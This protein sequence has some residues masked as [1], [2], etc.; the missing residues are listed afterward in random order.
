MAN[1]RSLVNFVKSVN[2]LPA[3][4]NGEQPSIPFALI[5][6]LQAMRHCWTI[7]R[8]Q[9]GLAIVHNKLTQDEL[10]Q[11]LECMEEVESIVEM[12]PIPPPLPKKFGSF[13]KNWHVFLEGFKGHC[14]V[15][16]GTLCIPL[17]FILREHTIISPEHR[18][19]NY[20]TANE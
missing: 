8:Q 14:S 13:G 6:L 12:K 1:D 10:K 18:G 5:R 9:C 3:D 20:I 7:E 2:K 15:V 17:A 11:I 16:R 19:A 4:Q